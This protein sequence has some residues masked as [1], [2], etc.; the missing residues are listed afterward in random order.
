MI[1][2]CGGESLGAV[3]ITQNPCCGFAAPQGGKA[4]PYR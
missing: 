2:E 1:L 3:E 4:L